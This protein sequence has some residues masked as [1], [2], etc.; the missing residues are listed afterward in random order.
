MKYVLDCCLQ[1]NKPPLIQRCRTTTVSA[2]TNTHGYTCIFHTRVV[3]KY[4]HYN[5]KEPTWKGCGPYLRLAN[6]KLCSTT[7][8]INNTLVSL[9]YRNLETNRFCFL[10]V[11]I[12][13]D[14]V[15]FGCKRILRNSLV[16]SVFVL[17]HLSFLET[18][19]SRAEAFERPRLSKE[20]G[21][22]IGNPAV[23]ECVQ[24]IS[25]RFGAFPLR[26]VCTGI[27]SASL[28]CA[29]TPPPDPQKAGPAA[30][31]LFFLTLPLGV[32]EI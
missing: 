5:D 20:L 31:L 11:L 1:I 32:S 18:V 10:V 29:G 27:L 19:H 14:A 12:R 13:E 28:S 3:K 15:G 4:E 17:F 16:F 8:C 30:V 2:K 9:R 23:C 21:P 22:P 24:I 6:S 7:T 25:G 26:A